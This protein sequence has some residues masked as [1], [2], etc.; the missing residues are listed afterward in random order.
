MG[1]ILDP[2]DV[3]QHV[4]SRCRTISRIEIRTVTVQ[5][6][7]FRQIKCRL[8]A[9]GGI[10]KKATLRWRERGRRIW[11]RSTT[12]PGRYSRFFANDLL[13]LMRMQR[14]DSVVL[15]RIATS[16]VRDAWDLDYRIGSCGRLCG[17]RCGALAGSVESSISGP[18][19]RVDYRRST[20]FLWTCATSTRWCTAPND[21]G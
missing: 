5:N 6:R 1:S 19:D 15:A 18:G 4:L 7:V 8:P 11:G 13:H 20:P 2:I 3:R 21:S 17:S 14:I 9:N 12:M 16:G 10:V